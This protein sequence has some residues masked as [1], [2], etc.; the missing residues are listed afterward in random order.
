VTVPHWPH[1]CRLRLHSR[2]KAVTRRTHADRRSLPH[3]IVKGVHEVYSPA[4]GIGD[5]TV[6]LAHKA[7]VRVGLGLRLS[8]RLNAADF[9]REHAGV[10][11]GLRVTL[12]GLRVGL[13][14]GVLETLKVA[15]S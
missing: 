2:H 12:L 4:H 10:F 8:T 13:H 1:G 6:K 7:F 5:A 3:R 11:T 14:E 15:H 9:L